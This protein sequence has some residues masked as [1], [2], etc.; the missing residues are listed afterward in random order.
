VEVARIDPGGFPWTPDDYRTCALIRAAERSHPT[1][2]EDDARDCAGELVECPTWLLAAGR[3][4]YGER[5]SGGG[6]ERHY[7]VF[8]RTS[9]KPF[10]ICSGFHLD[11]AP[12]ANGEEPPSEAQ[13]ASIRRFLDAPW[14]ILR[15]CVTCLSGAAT[16]EYVDTETGEARLARFRCRSWRCPW[17]GAPEARI[18]FARL[19]GALGR[20]ETPGA[21]PWWFLTLTYDPSR[22]A[23]IR[24]GYRGGGRATQSLRDAIRYRLGPGGRASKRLPLE[25]AAVWERTR[26]G[27]PHQHLVLRAPGMEG[28][29]ERQ[30]I[31]GKYKNRAGDLRP[32]YRWVDDFLRPAA[33]RAGFGRILQLEKA[34]SVDGMAAYFSKLASE[35]AGTKAYQQPVNAPK[36]FRRL[37]TSRGLI[38]P[39]RRPDESRVGLLHWRPIRDVAERYAAG[40]EGLAL[41]GGPG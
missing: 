30:G 34:E 8:L 18:L 25:H 16:L 7:L 10:G 14:P 11:G 20:S 13:T 29:V 38:P 41:L 28:Q 4:V 33:V 37:R 6:A 23:T 24:E 32:T 40:G 39:R 35:I 22:T 2:A 15:S 1:T 9:Q 17:C 3:E 31:T 19:V 26:K 36:G 27:W 21:E 5:N 12:E